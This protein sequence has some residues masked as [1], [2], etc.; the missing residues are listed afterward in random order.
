V[1]RAADGTPILVVTPANDDAGTMVGTV[2]NGCVAVE[3]ASID[4]PALRRDCAGNAIVRARVDG[5][6][7]A[8]CSHAAASITGLVGHAHAGDADDFS[9]HRTGVRP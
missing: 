2:G 6:T 4:P 5:G 9:I 1:A 3:L 7:M 8:A